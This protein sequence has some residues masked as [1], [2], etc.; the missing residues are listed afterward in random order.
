MRILIV[1]LALAAARPALA[2]PAL[3]ASWLAPTEPFEIFDGVWWVGTEGLAAY[4]F[5]TSDGLIL[6]DVGMP[7]AAEQVLANIGGLGL[8]P[9]NVRV[10]LNSHAHF[11]HSGGLAAVKAATGARLVAS[12]ED[13]PALETGT[14]P[15]WESRTVLNFPPVTVDRVIADGE[16]V[17]VGERTLTAHVTPGHSAGC[18]SWSF[19]VVADGEPVRALVFC[20][21]SVALNRLA[22]DPQVADY[23]GT[24]A[25]MKAMDVDAWLAPHPEQM[26]LAEKRARLGRDGPHP[27][28]DPG[29]KDRRIAD[30]EAAFEE[31]LARQRRPSSSPVGAE[32]GD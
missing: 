28:V 13:R 9:A 16:T 17:T 22:P 30:F 14:Y 1:L 20:S 6:L 32:R 27:F 10:L 25:R 21:A 26:G 29:E 7:Q 15:G 8:D 3:P 2:E 23:R 12:A 4:L 18:T 5:E 11:D 19:E 24:L 31:A